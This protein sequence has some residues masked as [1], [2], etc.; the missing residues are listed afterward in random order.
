MSI[1][2]V[3]MPGEPRGDLHVWHPP[4]HALSQQTPS[5]QK[6][7]GHSALLAQELPSTQVR[8]CPLQSWSIPSEQASVA[9]G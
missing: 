7:V 8:S 6:P 1:S 3:Q 9:P 5:T 4:S 2:E